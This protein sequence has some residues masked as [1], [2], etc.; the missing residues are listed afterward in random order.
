MEFLCFVERMLFCLEQVPVLNTEAHVWMFLQQTYDVQASLL[1]CFPGLRRLDLWV[2]F[3][4]DYEDYKVQEYRLAPIIR[5]VCACDSI[6]AWEASGT[7][8]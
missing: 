4:E 8:A 3:N 6:S 7:L 1:P 5:G 2:G